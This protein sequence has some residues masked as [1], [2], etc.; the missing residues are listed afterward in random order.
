MT[1]KIMGQHAGQC[2]S[3]AFKYLFIVRR[4]ETF[5]QPGRLGVW[6]LTEHSR[7]LPIDAGLFILDNAN[8]K[9]CKLRQLQNFVAMQT[10][11]GLSGILTGYMNAFD[12]SGAMFGNILDRSRKAYGCLRS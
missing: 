12:E 11:E 5:R 10:K 4:L 3:T 6:Y 1:L 7:D 2:I 9:P 8:L